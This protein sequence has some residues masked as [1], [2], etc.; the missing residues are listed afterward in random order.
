MPRRPPAPR[1]AHSAQAA[2]AYLPKGVFSLTLRTPVETPSLSHITAM[3]GLPV[4]SIPFPKLADRA[5]SPR[6]LRPPHATQLHP[7]MP[8]EPLLAPPSFPPPLIPLL[9]SPPSSMALKPLTPPLLPLAT[10]LRHSPGPYKRAMRPPVLTA[11]HHLSPKLLRALLRPRDKLRPPLFAASGVPPR[12][13]S[14]VTGEHRLD[15]LVLPLRH[16]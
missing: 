7:R 8:P 11:P 4:S 9:T 3:W 6:R 12:C 14:S 2:L 15:R 16:R 5:I 1:S 13:H 10:P